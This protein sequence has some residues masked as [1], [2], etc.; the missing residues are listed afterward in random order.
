[1]DEVLEK[2]IWEMFEQGLSDNEILDILVEEGKNVT[3]MD[4][5]VLR[6]DYEAEHPET[7]EEKEESP[8]PRETAEE[9]P[10]AEDANTVVTIDT[11]R[12]PGTLASGTA[13]LPSGARVVWALDQFGRLAVHPAEGS[14]RPTAA[15]LHAFQEEFRREIE[16]RGGII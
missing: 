6:A 12:K 4:L 3:Y 5:R 1:M 7:V 16:R 10:A 14:P 8:E 13:K 15:D 9:E 11:V 2:R